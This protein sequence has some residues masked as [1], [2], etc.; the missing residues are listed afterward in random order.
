[1]PNLSKK[2]RP[3]DLCPLCFLND[4]VNESLQYQ[5]GKFSHFCNRGHEFADREQLS[6]LMVEVSAKRRESGMQFPFKI[7]PGSLLGSKTV[8][9]PVQLAEK[10]SDVPDH[11]LTVVEATTQQTEIH[12]LESPPPVLDLTVPIPVGTKNIVIGPVDFARLTSILG[13]FTDSATLFGA[14]CSLNM[15]LADE[16]ELRTRAETAKTL[17]TGIRKIGGDVLVQVI[18]PER[19]VGPIQDLAESNGL[20]MI[21]YLNSRIEQ[22]LDD[23]W[24]Y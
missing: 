14:V 13:H 1:M 6:N 8:A 17:A 7:Q 15:Q 18:I 24:F 4:N 23:M 16:R 20:D 19:H 12:P 11:D 3:A 5:T 22:G 21:R 9:Q 10:A 2:E